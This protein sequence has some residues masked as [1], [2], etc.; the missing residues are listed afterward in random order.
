MTEGRESAPGLRSERFGAAKPGD[1]PVQKITDEAIRDGEHLRELDPKFG[2][3][4]F[5]AIPL[6]ALAIVRAAIKQRALCEAGS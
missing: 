3:R 6:I 1:E 5:L 4:V 2:R